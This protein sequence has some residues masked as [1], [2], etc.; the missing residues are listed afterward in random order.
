MFLDRMKQLLSKLVRFAVSAMLAICLV[1]SSQADSKEAVTLT[2]SVTDYTHTLDSSQ[3]NLLTTKLDNLE[4]EKGSQVVVLIVPTT[5]DKTIEEYSLEVAEKNLIGRK[6]VDDGVLFL[7]AKNDRKMRIEVG[8]G[9]EGAI[10]DATAKQIIS[11]IVTP[12]FKQGN[13]YEGVDSGLNAIT[14][15]INGE[16]LPVPQV[17]QVRDD[18][19]D[20]VT[21]VVILLVIGSAIHK[22]LFLFAS[23]ESKFNFA[24][25]FASILVLP[26]GILLFTVTSGLIAAI[27]LYFTLS[28]NSRDFWYSGSINDGDSWGG[29]SSSSSDWSGGGGSFGGGGASGSW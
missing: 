17:A 18:S 14:K 7:I 21:S 20:L 8:Y 15:R 2:S 24:K 5:E 22:F 4:K 19:I 25:A 16:E 6:G 11:D 26:V 12:Y 9:L 27:L 1:G 28:T 23:K 29:G 13:F 10:P 3:I